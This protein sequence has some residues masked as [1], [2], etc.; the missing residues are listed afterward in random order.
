MLNETLQIVSMVLCVVGLLQVIISPRQLDV[1]LKDY[2]LLYAS[3]FLYSGSIL[4]SLMLSGSEGTEAHTVLSVSVFLEFFMLYVMTFHIIN[5]LLTRVQSKAAGHEVLAARMILCVIFLGQTALLTLTQFTGFCYTI[6]MTNI[7][8]RQPGIIWHF[9]IMVAEFAVGVYTLLRFRG[10]LRRRS[11]LAFSAFAVLFGTALALQVL[12]SGVY[13]ITIASAFSVVV[14]FLYVNV[15]NTELHYQ[16]ERTIE[17]LKVDM[18]LSQIQPHF[19]FNSLTTIKHLC[20]TDPVTAEEAVAKF[21]VFLRGNMDS[22]TADKPIGFEDELDHTRAYLALEK[23]RFGDDLTIIE[24]I[25]CTSFLIPS[26]TLQPIVENAVRHGIRETEDGKGTV[27]VLAKEYP[28]RYEVTVTD[29][30][31]GFDTQILEGDDKEHLG[32]RNA[33]YRLEHMAGGSLLIESVAGRGTTVIL[34]L[35]KD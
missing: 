33:R 8:H 1:S 4:T 31:N 29:D 3:L 22:L 32:I 6:D 25:D 14:L 19:L 23:L 7:Y 2:T 34:V 12:F 5:W 26:L 20:R 28:D 17:K 35:P 15:E 9:V 10:A 24:H 11:R 21:S 30:G 16:N 27:T 18:M 13:Y